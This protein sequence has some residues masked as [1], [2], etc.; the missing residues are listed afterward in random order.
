MSVGESTPTGTRVL[1]LADEMASQR[2]GQQLATTLPTRAVVH[3]QGD[4]GA[5]KTT[6]ARALLRALGVEGAIK[7]PTYTLIERYPVDRGEV[8]HL[9]LYRIADPEELSFLGLD[10][11]V[12]SARLW[13]VEWPDRGATFLP[14]ADLRIRLAVAGAGRRA[15]LEALS[16]L[17]ADWLTALAARK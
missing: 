13:L 14:A 1:D 3:L 15:E 8:A 7:S 6:L 2:L 16:S 12:D 9:D 11:L 4:L 5:G 10:E 17:G